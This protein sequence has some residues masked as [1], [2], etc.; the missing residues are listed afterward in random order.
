MQSA[1]ED[2]WLE[3]VS[4]KPKLRV[5]KMITL[6]VSIESFVT[7]NLSRSYRSFLAQL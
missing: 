3:E 6:N 4:V 5:Y 1:Y 7:S 2:K